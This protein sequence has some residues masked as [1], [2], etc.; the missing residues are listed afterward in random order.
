MRTLDSGER[1]C[2]NEAPYVAGVLNAIDGGRPQLPSSGSMV[3]S[4]GVAE[5]DL[6]ERLRLAREV[7]ARRYALCFW[8][9]P[10]DIDITPELLPNV[11]HALREHG[12][13]AEV[14]LSEAICPSGV[15]FLDPF[16]EPPTSISIAESKIS[17]RRQSAPKH[18]CP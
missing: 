18:E 3:V 14:V 2:R 8:S 15:V 9:W 4:A 17:G 7:F 12:G 11:A 6:E 16:R 5:Y 10:R 1:V 13:R